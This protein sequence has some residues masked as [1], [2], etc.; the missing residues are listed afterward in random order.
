MP[1]A[2]EQAAYHAWLAWS[3]YR[4]WTYCTDCGERAYCGARRQRG[5]WLCVGCFDLR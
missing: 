4:K 2:L 5:P 1:S 3:A